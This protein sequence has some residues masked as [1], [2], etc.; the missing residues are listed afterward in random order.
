V[1]DW[2]DARFF[3]SIARA[4]SLSGAARVL[5]VQQSTV[6]RR[7]VALESAL[8]ARLFERT[9]DGYVLTPA[10]ESLQARAE[11]VEDE[12]LSAERELLGRE[13]KIAGVVRLTAPEAFGNIFLAPVLA[14][15]RGEQPDILVEVV[16]DNAAL[17]LTK[18]EA[19]LALRTGR[20][21]QPLLVIRRL[22][23]LANGLYASRGYLARRRRP[24]GRDLSGHDVIEYDETYLGKKEM[25]WL[26]QRG[27][28]GR[29]ALRVKGSHGVAAAIQADMGIGS[30][31]C[32]MGD[33]LEGVER[34]L[35]A[36]TYAEELWMILHRDLRHVARIRAVVDFLASE[37]RQAAP[38]LLGRTPRRAARER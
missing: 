34:V 17:S 30:L 14:R 31:P 13:S 2:D 28:G 12:M 16:A 35:P 36:E 18:R 11:R 9:P 7:L 6:G 24:Q 22:G 4:R 33:G 23:E 10:G 27:Q 5:R 32:W 20:P 8:G 1:F 19:D 25:A 21:E 3:L 29:C 37:L 26:Q 15:L 38:R